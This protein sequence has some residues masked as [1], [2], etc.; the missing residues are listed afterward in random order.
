MSRSARPPVLKQKPALASA[1]RQNP[2]PATP[3]GFIDAFYAHVMP[4]DLDL[5]SPKERASI[6]ASVWSLAQTRRPNEFKLRVFNPSQEKDGWASG[7]TAIEIVHEDMPFLVDSV[8][9]VLQNRGFSV[10]M[11]FHPVLNIRRDAQHKAMGITLAGAPGSSF[12]SFMHI[13]IDRGDDAAQL[14][15]IEAELR[16]T[17]SDVKASVKDWP[18][19]RLRMQEAAEKL[20]LPN[21]KSAEGDDIEE[22]RAFLHWL[23]DD[24]FTFLGYRE[25]AFSQQDKA[26]PAVTIMKGCGLG[27]LRDDAVRMFGGLRDAGKNNAPMMRK[28]LRWNHPLFVTKTH[29]TACVH[30]IVPMDAVFVRQFDEKGRMTG[31]KLFVGLFTAKNYAQ[32]PHEIPVVRRKIANVVARMNFAPRSHNG[33]NLAHILATYP[34]DELFQIPEEE[35]YANTLGILQLQERARVAL[36]VRRDPFDHCAT[37]LVYVPR[38]R[39]DSTLREKIKVF[40]EDAYQGALLAWHVRI[41]E[42]RL[43]RAFVTLRL[44]PTSPYPDPV[45]LEADLREMC[46]TWPDR[47]RDRMIAAYGEGEALALLRRYGKAFPKA[48][49]EA[50][51]PDCAVQDVRNLERARA[52]GRLIVDFDKMGDDR[53]CLK[54]LQPDRPLLLSES[55]PLIENMGLKIDYMGGPYEIKGNDG[56][57]PVYIHKFVGKP[58]LAAHADFDRVKPAFEDA[59]T[60]VWSGEVEN[61]AFNALTLRAGLGWREIVVLR[62]FARYLR[63]LRIPYSHEMMAEALVQHPQV[64]QQIVALFFT[65]HDPDLNGNRAAKQSA[66]ESALAEALSHIDVLEEDRIIRR[67]LNLVQASVRTNYFQTD[68]KGAFKPYLSIKFDSRAV[69]FM[70]LPRPLYEIFVYSP[71]VEAIHL[72]GGKV[73]RGGIRWSDRR[74]DFRAEVLGLM[75]AQMVKNS[76]I[77]PVGSKGGFIVKHPPTGGD[78]IQAEGIACYTLMMRGMFDVTD[79]IKNGKIV[80]PARVVRHDGDDPYLVIGADKGTATFSDIANGIA[81]DY[82]FWLDDAFASGGSAGYDH[83]GMGIT[84]RGAWEAIKRHFREMGKDIQKQDF[85]CVGVGDMSGDVFGNGML[86]SPCTRLIGAFDHRH[87]FCDPAPDAA[88]SFTERKRMF[89]LQRSSWNDY[90]RKLIS[91]GGGV[92]SRA[93]KTIK[94]TAEMKKAYGIASDTLPPTDL[95]QAM[96]KADIDLLYFGGIGTYVKASDETQD[97]AGDR[98]NEALRVNGADLRAKVVGEG[99]NLGM[100]QRGRIEYAQA[101]GRLNTDAID[102]SAGVDT[103]D[104]EVNIKVLLRRAI[105]RKMLSFAAR[106]KLLASMTDDVARLVLRDNYL[107]TQILSLTESRSPD[108]LQAHLRCMQI[109][110]KSGLLNRKVEYLPDDAE[111]AERQRH[112][113]GLT[114][115]E[116]AVLLPYAKLWLY[117]KILDSA[118]PDDPALK[119]DVENYFPE[120]LQKAYAKDIA[121]HQ[122]R[123]EIAA[124]VA[125]ND[126]INRAGFRIIQTMAESH[127]PESVVRAYLLTRDAFSLTEIWD[128]IEALDNKVPAA[129]QTRM[130]I[131]VHTALM[132]AIEGMLANP[133][134]L[135]D[136][137]N[138]IAAGRKGLAQLGDRLS[139]DPATHSAEKEW[140][141]AGAPQDLAQRLALLPTLVGAFD[142]I[143]LAAKNKMRVGDLAALFFGLEARLE[144]GWLKRLPPLSAQTSWQREA[145]QRAL[146]ELSAHHHRLT[147]QMASRK[148]K[149]Q[150]VAVWAAQNAPSLERYDALLSEGR[151]AGTVDL[152]MLMLVNERLRS[153]SA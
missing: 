42:S 101:G 130:L 30:R 122:L 44:N 4:A 92:F 132:Q 53:L 81:R 140:Q 31:E 131:A 117:E 124:T 95:I 13:E 80:P 127:D 69:D 90:D 114:R 46:R 126:I 110:E 32:T 16:A 52:A 109:L 146:A 27:V 17:L 55:L 97:E 103:S 100:T 113:K 60:K 112:G 98:A 79:N 1:S 149:A 121:Q 38:D 148:G 62:A 71:R 139:R 115:P 78:K 142:L 108:L 70:P 6:A 99:A 21:G 65:R 56:L 20:A 143:G 111:I 57:A 87:I 24:N 128:G 82:G 9:G 68:A 102:N 64:A 10:H 134:A 19:M 5:F 29:A 63:Q 67:Y 153:L 28:Y 116:M 120:A 51:T 37:F 137:A 8:T 45:K 104:H 49:C 118:L 141:N 26:A 152:A 40:L 22:V 88:K 58:A 91:K 12:E 73:S 2:F 48:Y 106:D 7:H 138:G 85:T 135:A 33:R 66:I 3:A 145:A 34:H 74:D 86:L 36:F 89:A 133:K 119:R 39:Y 43:A 105:D 75:K 14:K 25:I 94:I 18:A 76:V 41:D 23:A 147:A 84:A 144:I 61:D 59:L 35:L 96:L 93:E 77:V 151:A 72:R 54:M 123:R 47:L 11:V 125:V 150:G 83:K 50:M 15:E 107:Q 136:L 129:A